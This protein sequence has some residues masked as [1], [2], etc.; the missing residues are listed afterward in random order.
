MGIILHHLGWLNPINNGII[1]ILG[2]AGFCP[3]TLSQLVNWCFFPR[4]FEILQVY[5]ENESQ[6]LKHFLL[7]DPL[8]FFHGKNP[9]AAINRWMGPNPNGS[10]QVYGSVDRGSCWRFLGLGD[11][12]LWKLTNISD[13]WWLEWR[14]VLFLF[15]MVPFRGQ[16]NRSFVVDILF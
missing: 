2:G 10:T 4:C 9:K 6:S 11:I 3:S 12:P 8:G 5:A 1:I 7:G 15:E 16:K 13:N 14:W